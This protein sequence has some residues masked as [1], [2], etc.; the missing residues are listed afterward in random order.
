RGFLIALSC[1]AAAV[2]A[3]CS[4]RGDKPGT[5]PEPSASTPP[6]TSTP[7]DPAARLGLVWVDRRAG[8]SQLYVAS[9]EGKDARN[10]MTLPQGARPA[11]VRGGNLALLAADAITVV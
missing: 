11:D 1:L 4:G 9:F 3:A 5:S 10:L 6:A 8:P 2:L 7:V